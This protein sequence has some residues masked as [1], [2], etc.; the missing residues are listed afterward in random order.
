MMTSNE[1]LR[2]ALNHQA[3]D[4]IPLDLGAGKA[5]K[6]H[7]RLYKK[8]ID[9]LGIEENVIVGTK[10][11]QLAHASDAFLERLECDA[12]V[13]YPLMQKK[14][15]AKPNDWEDGE[16]Y[17]YRD[18]WGTV[19]RMP[20]SQPLY[21]DIHQPPLD[22][23]DEDKDAIY[24]HPVPG[25]IDPAAV[26]QVKNYAAAGWAVSNVDIFGNGFLQNGPKLFGFDDWLVMLAL[27]EDRVR[28]FL[29]RLLET[30][31]QYYDKLFAAFG[32]DLFVSVSEQEDLGT[33]NYIFV[34]HDMFRSLFK[35]YWVKLLG[36]IKK[37]SNAK[38]LLHSCGAVEPLI[39]DF[40]DMGVD[41]LNPV[42]IGAAGMDPY[43]LKRT[44]GKDI[45]FWGGGVD[46]Q[47][48]LPHG[49]EQEIRDHVKRNIDAFAPDGG[50]VFATVH[51]A[52]AD[53]PV[54]NF[55]TMWETFMDNRDY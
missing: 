39:G 31:M 16:N 43:H 5:C 37:L 51:N 19:M 53:V 38:I 25:D 2:T 49:T 52:Q 10:A 21:Y 45:S 28:G 22:A 11:T 50:F 17:Y 48:I 1:R 32:P 23:D 40:I 30:K 29:D 54:K 27:E 55:M 26:Q 8:L 12:R 14:P 4:R 34:S 36:H 3:P 35:P 33:Q 9:H 7:V 20:K 47:R 42:Q 15:G 18:D 13:P 41:I 46:T 24:P 44:Y 6:I